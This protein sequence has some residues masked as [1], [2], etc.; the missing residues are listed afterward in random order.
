[1]KSKS[2]SWM[3]FINILLI[4]VVTISFIGG[5]WIYDTQV[6]SKIRSEEMIASKMDFFE[7][8]LKETVMSQ[9]NHIVFKQDLTESILKKKIKERTYEAY[10]IANNIYQ[11]YKYEKDESAIKTLIV[12]TLRNIRFNEDRGYYFIDTMSGDVVL[13]PILPETEGENLWFF[14]D[15]RGNFPVQSEIDTVLNSGEGFVEAYWV[16]PEENLD[17]DFKKITFV[18]YFEPYDWYL[19]C[20]EYIGD[21]ENDIK[22]EVLEYF[23]QL[24]F[25]EEN[26]NYIFIHDLNGMELANGKYP[27]MVGENYYNLQNYEGTYVIRD[28][29]ELANSPEEGGF[30]IHGWIDKNE[31]IYK[32]TYVH[33]VP[34]WNWVIGSSLNLTEIQNI[35]NKEQIRLDERKKAQLYKIIFIAAL[36]IGFSFFIVRFLTHYISKSVKNVQSEVDSAIDQLRAIETDKIP[37][38]DFHPLIDKTNEMTQTISSLIHVDSLTGLYNKKF[39][40]SKIEEFHYGKRSQSLIL[41]DIDHYGRISEKYGSAISDQIFKRVAQLT[42]QVI[43]Y[44]GLTARY[45]GK[46]IIIVLPNT[47]KEKAKNIAEA[48]RLRIQNHEFSQIQEKVTI[49]GSVI[50]DEYKDLSETIQ[51]LEGVMYKAKKLGRNQIMSN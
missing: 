46:Q 50:F 17:L 2:L 18:K 49:S 20:G 29:I 24:T 31:Y 38:A 44:G 1:M 42:Q 26:E 22:N 9:I 35:I 12:E 13:Y 45:G 5:M 23:N 11:T 25:G 43:D 27:E 51:K 41:I 6:H 7:A 10:E 8:A 21:V 4:I 39:I 19:G 14:E 48:I 34:N 28:Q 16:K 40:F 32:M 15:S 37:F 3:M 33:K 36:S 30:L 47:S